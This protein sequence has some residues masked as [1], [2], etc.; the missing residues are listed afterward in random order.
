M[1]CIKIIIYLGNYHYI[2]E[3]CFHYKSSIVNYRNTILLFKKIFTCTSSRNNL[4]IVTK[5][6]FRCI[7]NLSSMWKRYNQDRCSIFFYLSNKD[8]FFETYFILVICTTLILY[9]IIIFKLTHLPW[10][11]FSNFL[12]HHD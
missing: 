7:V 6:N 12:I 2:I 8:K 1:L 4:N 11:N 9:W 10:A 3:L 5:G